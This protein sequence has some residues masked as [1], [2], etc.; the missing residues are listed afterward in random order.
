ME[1]THAPYAHV[2]V[3]LLQGA[4]YDDNEKIWNDLLLYQVPIS[5]Y[6]DK[7]AMDLVVERK[8]GYAYLKQSP[9]DDDGNTIGLV[10]RIP[11]QY[12]L[13]L[14]LVLLRK[15][16]DDFEGTNTEQ[17]NLYISHKRIKEELEIFFKETPNKVK[18]IKELDNYI[19]K[20]EELDFL[21]KINKETAIKD[22]I[23]YEV[24]RIIKAKITNDVLEDF[25]R[26]LQ[27][28]V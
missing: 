2:A 14:L 18:L 16:M 23:Q 4:I 25:K 24:R 10:R 6:F 21:K 5:Q 20:A 3:K 19:K 28:D 26:K 15:L 7:I 9:I 8:D 11:I 22:E 1:N 13:S 17:R 27:K 12:E